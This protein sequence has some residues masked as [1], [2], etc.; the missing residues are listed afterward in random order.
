[1]AYKIENTRLMKIDIKVYTKYH[2][3]LRNNVRLNEEQ[4]FFLPTNRVIS[5][6]L[7]QNQQSSSKCSH[8]ISKLSEKCSV[9]VTVYLQ[10]L[11]NQIKNIYTI[12]PR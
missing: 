11:E 8:Y 1:M 7:P 6:F 2:T 4:I 12:E 10:L 9:R 5:I 3:S